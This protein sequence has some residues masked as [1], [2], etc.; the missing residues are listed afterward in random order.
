MKIEVLGDGCARCN[1]LYE[2]VLEAVKL[3]GTEVDV[4]KDMDVEKIADHQVKSMPAV[5]VDG[6]VKIS[7]KVP[8][9]SEILTWIK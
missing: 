5:L 2:N 4:T 1:Q 6:V 3:S 7:G 8:K 9:V